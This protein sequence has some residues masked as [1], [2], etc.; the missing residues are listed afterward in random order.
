[1]HVNSNPPTS[2][3]SNFNAT[4][5]NYSIKKKIIAEYEGCHNYYR[6]SK[7]SGLSVSLIIG[8]VDQKQELLQHSGKK[9]VW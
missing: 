4:Q 3:S 8:W 7:Q 6:I 9:T 1:M 5:K 2:S